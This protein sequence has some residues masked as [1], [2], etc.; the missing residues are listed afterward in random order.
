MSFFCNADATPVTM[1]SWWGMIPPLMVEW[2]IGIPAPTHA[3]DLTL[4]WGCTRNFP[5]FPPSNFSKFPPISLILTHLYPL[6]PIPPHFPP[7]PPTCPHFP[8]FPP[9]SPIFPFFFG[10]LT[11]SFKSKMAGNFMG[12][13]LG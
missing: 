13:L 5:L 9:I 7:L 4:I 8:P 10:N 1:S 12:R 2:L 11:G 6:F 3:G